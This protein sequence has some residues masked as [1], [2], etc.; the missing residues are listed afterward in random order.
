MKFRDYIEMHHVFTVEQL[1]EAADLSES[2]V[3]MT[4]V[5]AVESASVERVR[6]GLYVSK[7]GRFARMGIDSFEVVA[8]LDETAVLSFHSALEAHG[9]AHNVSSTC[10]FRTS[11]VKAAFQYDGVSYMPYASDC[12]IETQRI[13]SKDGVQL[14]ATSREQTIIDCL[15][16]PDRSGGIEEVLRSLSLFPYVNVKQLETMA[17]NRSASLAARIGWLLNKKADAWR[18]APGDLEHFEA[19]AQ[20]GPF[21]LDKRS[22]KSYG[23]SKSW[24]LC[25]PDS[26]KEVESWI[27]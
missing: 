14:L 12:D 16:Y 10:R 3:H 22:A 27:L 7:V 4:L 20:G 6:R 9:V 5:R 17:S 11:N 21:K 15:S 25:L 8:A 24:R 19:L 23:W 13:R 26:E 18:V 1:K 2:S